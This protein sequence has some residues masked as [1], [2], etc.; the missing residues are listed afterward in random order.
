VRCT[1]DLI[2]TCWAAP[3][4]HDSSHLQPCN[5]LC[6]QHACMIPACA[7]PACPSNLRLQVVRAR[8]GHPCKSVLVLAGGPFLHAAAPHT[9][10]YLQLPHSLTHTHRTTHCHSRKRVGHVDAA[11][12]CVIPS[13]ASTPLAKAAGPY[14]APAAAAACS[15]AACCI[16]AS[17]ACLAPPSSPPIRAWYL[18]GL[19][20]WMWLRACAHTSSG[21]HSAVS[22]MSP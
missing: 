1:S 3:Q 21:R 15:A 17:T 18:P 7:I 4:P 11:V 8:P 12:C 14:C 10:I 20:P 5:L 2:T 13:H 19:L 16:I 9:T 22:L 6:F